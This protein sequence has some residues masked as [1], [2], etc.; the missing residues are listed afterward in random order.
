MPNGMP[1]S[2]HCAAAIFWTFGHAFSDLG[3]KQT[4]ACYWFIK[5]DLYFEQPVLQ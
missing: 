2:C 5:N 4:K 1:E 3:T